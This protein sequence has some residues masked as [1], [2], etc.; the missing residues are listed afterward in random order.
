M[1]PMKTPHLSN[2]NKTLMH[3]AAVALLVLTSSGAIGQT[4][5]IITRPLSPQDLTDYKLPATTQVSGG[6]STIGLGTPAYLDAQVLKGTTVSNVVWALASK[7]AGSTAVLAPSPLG[8]N[9]PSFEPADRLAYDIAGRQLL[10]PDVKGQYTITATVTAGTNTM[11]LTNVITAGTYVGIGNIDG[12]TP[13]NNRQCA[14]CHDGGLTPDKIT[15]WSKTG[16]GKMLTEGID[17]ILSSSYKASC[18]SCH[19]T[20]YNTAATAKNGGF[21]DVAASLGWTF[22]TVLTNGNW[23]ALPSAL[24]QVSNIQCESCH[25]PGSEHGG[26]PSKISVD[27]GA[28]NC[29]QC[30]SSGTHHIKPQEWVN[31]GHAIAPR[32][33]SASCAGCHSGIGFIDRV[34]GATNVRT[35]YAA[36]T[37][38]T[39][40][41]PHDATNPHQL[42]AQSSVRLLDTS[43]AGGPT[44][45]TTGGKGALCMQCHMSRR[46]AVS[47]VTTATANNRFGPHHGPQTDMLM[48]VN[49]I[50]YGQSIPSSAHG[51]VVADT[52]VA[53]HMQTVDPT[54]SVFLHAGGHTFAVSGTATNNATVQ[55]VAA[56]QGCHGPSV[57]T[58]D[59]A[60]VDYD[61][62]GVIQ[63]VQTEVKGL[64]SQLSALLPPLGQ[65][66]LTVSAVSSAITTNYTAAQ[67]KAVYNL[68]FVLE[69]G[70][71]GIH[72]TA[73]AVGLLKAS[74]ADL[75]GNT[76]NTGS[77]TDVNSAI[78]NYFATSTTYLTNPDALGAGWF[79]LGITNLVGWKLGVQ[80]S[81][82]L[83]TWTNLPTAAMPVYQ[84]NDPAAASAQQRF[85]RFRYP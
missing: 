51:Q 45:V 22:P 11:V 81:S 43:K 1:N 4:P 13:T 35:N 73:Y 41:D 25:G 30:H 46:D 34:S 16:H 56:C 29:A 44:V 33:E 39:C 23:A 3:S 6:L 42:R 49:A 65:P 19:T 59:M 21:D 31:S 58:F 38:A 70:S 40:H 77:V 82:D 32:E 37:C 54:N 57:T 28:G 14:Q 26:N 69:D 5:Q 61:G 84:F 79:Q 12:A 53:C 7:P 36:V 2:A 68:L 63:G 9:V 8:A 50:T 78:A 24:K 62:N 75:G 18:I 27:F 74:I 64:V 83:V 71:Y 67:R 10:I 48:G 85:Y 76:G 15:P 17:G 52:C 80:A 20:G 55:L 60:R 66:K 47:Y 72:N